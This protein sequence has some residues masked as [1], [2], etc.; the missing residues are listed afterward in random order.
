MKISPAD[1]SPIA[2]TGISALFP[3]SLDATGFWRDILAGE[4]RI[5]EV[6]TSHW[7]IEDYYDPDPTVPDKT[8]GKRGGFLRDVPFDSMAWGI[9]PNIVPETDTSQLLALIVAQAV[10]DDATKAGNGV[11]RDRTSVILGVTSGQEL[12]GSMVSRLQRPVWIKAL[13]E[14]G[15]P[16]TEAIAICERIASHYTDWNESTFPGLLGN[17]VAGRIANRLDLGGTNCVTDAA[18]AS[19]FSALSMAVSE[20]QLGDSDAVIAGGVDAMNDIFMFMC[21]SK[22]PALSPTGDCRPFSDQA[23]GT[24]LGEGLGMVLLKRLEDAERDGDRIYAVINSVGAS[25]DGRSKSVYAPVSAGQAKALERAYELAGYGPDTVELLEA[26]GTGT[27]AGDAAEFNGLCLAFDRQR[28]DRQWCA[29]GSVKSQ[30]GHTKSAAGAAGLLKA[31]LAVHHKVLPPTIKI[32][33]PNPALDIETSPFH[34]ALRS[35]PW[36]RGR[37]HERRASVSSFGFGG[38]NFHVTVSEY[39]EKEDSPATAAPRLRAEGAELLLFS[40]AEAAGVEAQLNEALQMADEPGA[41]AFLAHR[42]QDRFDAQARCRLAMVTNEED[43]AE[44]LGEAS[45]HLTR[46]PHESFETPSG[47]LYRDVPDAGSRDD[48]KTAFLFSGQGSQYIDMGGE[49]AMHFD[50]AREPW[51]LAAD[52]D[53]TSSGEEN[54][55]LHQVVFPPNAFSDQARAEHSGRLSATEWAQPAIGCV[56]LSMLSLLGDLGLAADAFAGHSFGEVTALCAAGA[57]SP[58]DFLEVA[59][60]RG[61]LMRDAAS[62]PGA[63]TAVAATLD[64]VQSVL[65]EGPSEV[66]VANHNHPEQVVLSGPTPA[67]EAI[68]KRFDKEGITARRLPVATAFHSPIVAPASLAFGE[69]LAGV[70]FEAPVLPVYSNTTATHH[71]TAPA[72]LRERIAEQLAHPVRYVDMIEAM[73]A[74]GVRTFVEV[75]PGSIQ[76]SLVRRI[77]G[78][79]PHR[80]VSLDRKGQHG[81][82]PF[83]RGIATLAVDG[84]AMSYE[85][86]WKGYDAPSDPRERPV[87]KLSIAINGANYGKPYPPLEGASVL[88]GPNPAREPVAAA[89]PAP[90]KPAAPA[91]PPA[92]PVATEPAAPGPQMAA[93]VQETQRQTA[94]AHSRY[95]EM[96]A[97][98]HTAF[99]DAMERGMRVATGDTSGATLSTE[100]VADPVEPLQ[101]PSSAVPAA[102]PAPPVAPPPERPASSPPQP[103]AVDLRA[104]MRQVVSEKTG[105]P[106]EMLDESMELEGD[107]GIDSIKRVEI[108]SEMTDRAPGLPEL[109]T[110]ELAELQTL[111]QVVAYLQERLPRATTTAAAPPAPEAVFPAIDLHQMMLQVV[112]EKTGYPAEMLDDAMELEGDLGID[113]IKR[114]EILSELTDR[115]PGL[116]ELDTAELAELQTLG[117]VVAYLQERL[118]RATTTAAT[119]PAPEAVFPA[120]DLH[121]MMLQVVSEKTGYPAEMLDDAMELEGDLGIDSIKRVEILSEMTDRA[122]GLPELDTAELAELQTLGQVVAYLEARLPGQTSA[123]TGEPMTTAGPETRDTT[124]PG[125]PAFGR[126]VLT[127]VERPAPGLAVRGLFGQGPLYVTEDRAFSEGEGVQEALVNRLRA[128]GIDARAGNVPA[129]NG[130]TP[131]LG[132]IVLSGLRAVDDAQDAT[133]VNRE[134]FAHAQAAA[135]YLVEASEG[136]FVTVQNT[137]GAFAHDKGRGQSAMDPDRAWLAGCAALARTVAAEWPRIGTKAIDI[138]G[139]GRTARE[140]ADAIAFELLAGGAELD[141]GL[142]ADGRRIL[143]AD[144]QCAPRPERPALEDG[145]VVVAAGGGRGVTAATLIALAGTAKLRF[146]LLG[147]TAITEEPACCRGVQGDAELKRALLTDASERGEKLRPAELGRTVSKILANREI[148]ATLSAIRAAGSEARYVATDVT[149]ARKL[150]ASLDEVRSSWGEIAGVVHGAGVL[151]DKLIGEKTTEQFDRVFDTKVLGLRALLEATAKDPLRAICLFS[152]VAAR[153]GNLGQS[154]YAMANEVLNK[155][156]QVEARRRGDSCVVKAMGWGPWKGGMVSDELAAHFE[157]QGVPLI[158]LDVGAQMLVDELDHGDAATIEVT[159]GGDPGGARMNATDGSYRSEV[160]I[161]HESHAFLFDHS[162][163]GTPVVPMVLALEWFAR[164]ARSAAGDQV[165]TGLS[166]FEVV[167]GIALPELDARPARFTIDAKPEAGGAELDLELRAPD[168]ALH[169][170][171]RA[172]CVSAQDLEPSNGSAAE[173]DLELE[174]WGDRV[175]YDHPALFHGPRFQVIEGVDGLSDRGIAVRLRGVA[176]SNWTG[177]GEQPP[178]SAAG[179]GWF[180]DPAA[181]DGGLQAAILWCDHVLDGRALPTRIDKVELGRALPTGNGLRCEVSGR[182]SANHRGISDVRFLDGNGQLLF[183]LR[184]LQTHVRAPSAS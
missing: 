20:L 59:R 141:V 107:L 31:V 95:L 131:P 71:P 19:T 73:Y 137:G 30:I 127:P 64:Q 23:D 46:A 77:L 139:H 115:A 125:S 37:D 72:T 2:I 148:D 5:T 140:I 177:K 67:V 120:I 80:A 21:F 138:E 22:T 86:L 124:T 126:F 66:V 116:P 35:R 13:R 54:H 60:R 182:E 178:G 16:E 132:V 175:I 97:E 26:H 90:A 162:I 83:L 165:V 129:T 123:G 174:P 36:V 159:L 146:V 168:G 106:S 167:R 180:T 56:S 102:S 68:E 179:G 55:R 104:V 89:A 32:D 78:D 121:Q 40:A 52:F 166:D 76:T 173:L 145:D 183:E 49:L 29:L 158:P 151:A 44:R 110:A 27:I 171:A 176:A 154:D 10:L 4:D 79:R 43:L 133:A 147:R 9:P 50:S 105:Y 111:A 88:P 92:P 181:L 33:K 3:G 69:F 85:A 94:E 128:E 87:P 91:R 45:G 101:P 100:P 47:T 6:P 93:A 149:D 48:G 8:Y 122:P 28:S 81:L 134:A 144:P 38:S 14:S 96:M 75:G 163:D 164:A 57:I 108:L 53:W 62:A 153:T 170:R 17:V 42:G 99:L 113:S 12:L 98:S 117:Q 130:S 155:V 74:D 7:L 136:V 152:S 169:Y 1:R 24:M 58:E 119:A 109:D 82:V 84:H 61:E 51:D 114:V 39:Q 142:L 25:S 156:A 103:A 11:D 172:R 65:G 34:F 18:C 184:G 118:P 63:M 41:L 15:V 70:D 143:L 161:D 160:R 135:P 150:A 157:S 112:S